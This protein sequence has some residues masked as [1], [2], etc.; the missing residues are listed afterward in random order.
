[1]VLAF[2]EQQGEPGSCV[3]A[4]MMFAFRAHLHVVVERLL[5]DHLPAMLALQPEPFG[6]DVLLPAFRR[7]AFSRLVSGKPRHSI[8]SVTQRG[9]RPPPASA[10]T[11]DRAGW[12]RRDKSARLASPVPARAE[13]SSWK[14]KAGDRPARA[15]LKASRQSRPPGK[16][17]RVPPVPSCP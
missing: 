7:L 1:L 8:L 11:D 5:P 9:T 10:D 13:T 17:C 16:P 15:R 6:A 12:R 4:K 2:V 14:E 3:D